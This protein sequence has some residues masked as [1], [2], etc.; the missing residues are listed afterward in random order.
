MMVM[1]WSTFKYSRAWRHDFGSVQIKE[2]NS[3][4]ST[5]YSSAW[6]RAWASAVT[7]S[8]DVQSIVKVDSCYCHIH[9]IVCFG[10]ICKYGSMEGKPASCVW[11][12][13]QADIC[14]SHYLL[15][16]AQVHDS[17]RSFQVPCRDGAEVCWAPIVQILQV[18]FYSD[19]KRTEA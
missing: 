14:R 6:S 13:L 3:L 1:G 4:V 12:L 2:F 9:A 19:S 11:E 8:W 17:F 18:G 15:M 16:K 7:F 10:A 5:I